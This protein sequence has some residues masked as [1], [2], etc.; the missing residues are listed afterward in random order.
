MW[1]S[2]EN[3]RS[4]VNCKNINYF[5][6]QEAKKAFC[7]YRKIEP[8]QNHELDLLN[9]E[10]EKFKSNTTPVKNDSKLKSKWTE[11]SMI[12]RILQMSR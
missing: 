1:R 7:F 12:L 2:G 6:L 3:L 4:C 11:F 9:N 10:M 5:I 8:Q